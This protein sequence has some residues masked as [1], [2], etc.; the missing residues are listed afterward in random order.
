MPFDERT[1][2][3]Y[4]L[5]GHGR[6]LMVTLPLMASHVEIFGEAARPLLDGYLSRLTDAYQVLL[7]DYPGIG[8]SR[9]VM[10]E[11]L[12][13]ERVCA[14]LLGVA[15]AAGFAR[16]AYWGYS[17]S[18]AVGLQLATRSDRLDALVIGGW[19]P[20]GAPYAAIHE[21]A[22]RKAPD[23]EPSSRVVLRT[24]AQ[25]RQW[26]E[27][28]D[29]LAGWDEAAAVATIACPRMVFFGAD[30]DLIEAGLPV[31]IA[32][33]IRQHR[34]ALEAAGWRVLEVP[35]HGHGVTAVPELVVPP[36]RTFLDEVLR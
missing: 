5:H 11:P 1:G 19:P 8:R 6:P 29:S 35:G 4:A 34:G 26:I 33:C 23:P 32:S 30:G 10:P 27:F 12:S 24:P 17:W 28:Y 2:I 36:V 7:V 21:A 14:D 22:R 31:P 3:H 18:G 9:D 15:S 20:L 25:Y 13:A 16:F